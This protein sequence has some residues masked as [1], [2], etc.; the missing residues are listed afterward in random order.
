MSASSAILTFR[1]SLYILFNAFYT[2]IHCMF[3]YTQPQ[4]Y[5]CISHKM[6][7]ERE[8]ETN[9]Q[10][11]SLIAI[12]A[13]FSRTSEPF[14]IYSCVSQLSIPNRSIEQRGSWHK[15][16][17]RAILVYR[18]SFRYVLYIC[19][20]IY[21]FFLFFFN[22]VPSLCPLFG[23]R[24]IYLSLYAHIRIHDWHGCRIDKEGVWA[25]DEPFL[26][27]GKVQKN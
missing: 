15:T 22:N 13:L 19:D 1:F 17:P 9:S 8:R 6:A 26:F 23:G 27:A 7:K 4:T 2:C 10:T 20:G 12:R 11:G 16:F 18:L 14:P 25:M 24:R 21:F 5:I 3:I